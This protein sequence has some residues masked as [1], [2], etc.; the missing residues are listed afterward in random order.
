M[1]DHILAAK[2]DVWP[3]QRSLPTRQGPRQLGPVGRSR[4]RH[5]RVPL[6]HHRDLCAPLLDQGV[7]ALQL[8]ARGDEGL[9]AAAGI[10]GG[11]GG[12]QQRLVERVVGVAGAQL[13]QQDRLGLQGGFRRLGR[14][15]V[16]HG[17]QQ[18]HLLDHGVDHHVLAL[19]AEQDHAG[20]V[21]T[22]H[23]GWI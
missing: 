8:G 3:Q 18:V 10:L 22:V 1:D 19:R 12:V 9:R 13:R 21:R 20:L 17:R 16:L 23:A 4:P 6:R 14:S 11:H 15:Q 5:G 2:A 7:E